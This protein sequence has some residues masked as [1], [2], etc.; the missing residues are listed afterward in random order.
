MKVI[1]EFFYDEN[2][3]QPINHWQCYFC[4]YIYIDFPALYGHILDKSGE[5]FY[6]KK[7]TDSA[8]CCGN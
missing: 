2:L 7:Q 5:L 6:N 4:R 1:L 3:A 8:D